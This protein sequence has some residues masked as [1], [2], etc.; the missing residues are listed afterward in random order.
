LGESGEN[1]ENDEK[2]DFYGFREILGKKLP[3]NLIPTYWSGQR[4]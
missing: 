1:G 3:K 2:V 4:F